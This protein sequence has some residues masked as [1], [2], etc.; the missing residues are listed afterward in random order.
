MP[1]KLSQLYC[2]MLQAKAA[3]QA[4]TRGLSRE[5]EPLQARFNCVAPGSVNTPM[6]WDNP[7]VKSGEEKIDEKK[8][9]QPEDI[10]YCS[11]FPGIRRGEIYKRDNACGGR[12]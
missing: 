7:K 4:F 3:F 6:L 8:L 11:V 12:R 9:G 5:Y 2:L 10:A 1:L